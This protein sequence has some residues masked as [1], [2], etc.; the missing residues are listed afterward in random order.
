MNNE[1]IKDEIKDNFKKSPNKNLVL[2]ALGII[3][4]II[5]IIFSIISNRKG[6]TEIPPYQI[7][8]EDKSPSNQPSEPFS[9]IDIDGDGDEEQVPREIVESKILM[10]TEKSELYIISPIDKE[11]ILLLDGVSAYASS[12]DKNYIAYLKTY[13]FV[14]D[15]SK[16]DSDIHIY[17]IK[18][19]QESK[20]VAGQGAQ[21]GVSWSPDGK[22]I[23]VERGTSVTGANDV[24]SVETGKNIGCSFSGTALWISNIEFLTALF[25]ENFTQRS[26]Q[27]MDAQGIR[28][29][30]IENCQSETFLLPTNTA[31]FSAVKIV[32]NNVIVQK[33]YVDKSE[34]W[35]DFSVE[36]KIKTTY[37]KYNLQTKLGTPYPEYENEI[38]SENDRLKALVPFT[39]K[40]KRVFTTDKDVATGW[41]LINVH[42][43]GSLYNNE[44]YLM[45][46]D[47][48]VVKIGE[49][50]FAT[51]L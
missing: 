32:D 45:G 14:T 31:N 21:R 35:G 3:A 30:N 16:S 4:L 24:Y 47:K 49:E 48:T 40:V 51:W 23:I 8:E 39:V 10:L 12:D 2:A 41:E 15:Q 43:G 50:A 44:V 26:G 27:M 9:S 42:K 28:K 17:N 13:P 36:S 34:D 29:I 5:L 25:A 11:K 46:P 33:T 6:D 7:T 20:I 37:E 22:Y 19:Q 38:N 1:K 18:T